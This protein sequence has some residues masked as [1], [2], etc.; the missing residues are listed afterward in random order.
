MVIALIVFGIIGA[1][2]V[3]MW[4]MANA[5]AMLEDWEAQSRLKDQRR[6]FK[7]VRRLRRPF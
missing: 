2:C 3:I 4:L 6:A 7:A 5:M 1:T